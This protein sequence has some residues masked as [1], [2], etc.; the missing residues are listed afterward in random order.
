MK[1]LTSPLAQQHLQRHS[2]TGRLSLAPLRGSKQGRAIT[3]AVGTQCRN[4][5]LRSTLAIDAGHRSGGGGVSR[6]LAAV[7]FV[8]SPLSPQ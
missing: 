3:S 2:F 4:L 6:P 5:L 7:A 1:T 8:Q